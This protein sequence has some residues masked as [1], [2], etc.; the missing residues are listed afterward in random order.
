MYTAIILLLLI[1]MELCARVVCFKSE[2]SHWRA[3][4]KY[5]KDWHIPPY[6]WHPFLG[7]VAK[8]G[9]STASCTINSAGF[10]DRDDVEYDK[11]EGEFRIF[12]LGGSVAFGA[13]SKDD[14]TIGAWLQKELEN[15]KKKVRVI[16]AGQPAFNSSQE[17][18]YFSLFIT[19]YKPDLVIVLNGRNDF[20]YALQ[21]G[22]VPHIHGRMSYFV[23]WYNKM[24]QE[25]EKKKNVISKILFDLEKI[26][27]H[28]AIINCC[29]KLWAASKNNSQFAHNECGFSNRRK[30]L[31]QGIE[32]YVG[33]LE[34]IGCIARERQIELL[35]VV[36]P[37]LFET[38]KELSENE[39]KLLA[40]LKEGDSFFKKGEWQEYGFFMEEII[41]SA[42]ACAK[43]IGFNLL[44]SKDVFNA[45]KE[46]SEI[47]LDDTHL[48][49]AANRK[50]A[51]Y[52]AQ[53][54]INKQLIPVKDKR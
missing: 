28:I 31:Q 32:Q 4:A 45:C 18:V 12:I 48:S 6:E 47:F 38:K 52:I 54:C 7:Q 46:D 51:E 41:Q 42:Y 14:E 9:F 16:I 17:Y 2:R 11:S 36:Q 10:R 19:M 22:W 44:R 8:A 23:D 1:L 34:K 50:L 33:N 39:E 53:Y 24:H 5:R 13:G 26:C 30:F 21:N 20:Y 3:N 43:K 40:G 35:V 29:Y 37:S 27:K 25:Q 49:A 15:V